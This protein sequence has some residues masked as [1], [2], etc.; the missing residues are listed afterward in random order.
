MARRI[1]LSM[2][3]RRALF[4]DMNEIKIEGAVIGATDRFSSA[5][6]RKIVGSFFNYVRVID[7]NNYFVKWD[8][9]IALDYYGNIIWMTNKFKNIVE[10]KFKSR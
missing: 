2:F 5:V 6:R 8:Y 3:S 10:L 1:K 4:D 7:W 9:S